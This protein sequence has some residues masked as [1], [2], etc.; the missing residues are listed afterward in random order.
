MKPKLLFEQLLSRQDLSSD[1]MQEVIHA[2]MTGEFSDVQIA[3]FL[4]L[5]RMKGETVNE[6]TAAAQ[7][8]RQLAHK[9]DL[10]NPLIDIVGT[11]GDGRN[12]FNVSTA[13]SFVVAAAGIKVAKHGNR[14]V[15]SR[16]GSA[17]LLEQAGFILNLSDSQVQNCINQ[18]QLAFLFAPHYHPAM[19]HARAARQ[20]LGIRTLF[21]LLGP[22][23]N[24]AQV[25]R[26]VVGVFSTNWLKTIAT[27]LANLGSERSLVISSQDGLDEISIAAKSEV[28]EYRDGNFKQWFISPE[29]YGLKHSS[30]DAII[31]DSPEQSLHLIQS[32]LSGDSGP[33][34][35]IVLLNSAAA[36]YCAKDGISFDAAIEEARIAIDSGKANL[37]FNKLRLLTQTLNKESNHE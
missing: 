24:P 36:I 14:S 29:D 20:Q 10:G 17:D 19:Q 23:I 1:Q 25:K 37:C 13:C 5:M 16:S 21:N 3:T 7:V 31:V 32:V 35:D 34:R 27:V 30:L 8:M 2:C 26:Q 11:G 18:C 15:S 9:I 12:T 33:A 28:V 4:A 6:L 22:L